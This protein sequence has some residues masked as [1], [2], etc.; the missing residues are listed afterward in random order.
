MTT[1]RQRRSP[2]KPQVGWEDHAAFAEEGIR[3][4]NIARGLQPIG[5]KGQPEADARR[6]GIGLALL[7]LLVDDYAAGQARGLEIPLTG[8]K[9]ALGVLEYLTNGKDHPVARHVKGINSPQFRRGTAPQNAA[10]KYAQIVAV[11]VVRAYAMKAKL[12]QDPARAAVVRSAA[13]AGIVLTESKLKSWHYTLQRSSASEP[14]M[15][16]NNLLRICSDANQVL[17]QGTA[18]IWQWWHVPD[19]LDKKLDSP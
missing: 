6:V 11:A 13:V 8:V 5:V 9:E 12:Q 1:S 2:T 10:D 4:Y 15:F 14:D 17:A 18:W 7:R 3:A 16:A 19:L